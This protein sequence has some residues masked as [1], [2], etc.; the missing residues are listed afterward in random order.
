LIFYRGV[1]ILWSIRPRISIST[2]RDFVL[3]MAD[4]SAFAIIIVVFEVSSVGHASCICSGRRLT[5]LTFLR[6]LW[7]SVYDTAPMRRDHF[8]PR[9]SLTAVKTCACTFFGAATTPLFSFS[10]RPKL[11]FSRLPLASVTSP[12]A[13]LTMRSPAAWSQIFS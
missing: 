13:S 11:K 8:R 12:P 6:S 5:E 4:T 2:F 1:L 10:V 3:T 9:T 7:G